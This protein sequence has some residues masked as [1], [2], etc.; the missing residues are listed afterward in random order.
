MTI[1]YDIVIGCEKAAVKFSIVG[2]QRLWRDSDAC[3]GPEK[4]LGDECGKV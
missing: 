1:S 2:L 3:K 4:T